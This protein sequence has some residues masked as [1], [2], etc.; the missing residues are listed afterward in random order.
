MKKITAVNNEMM[1]DSL[2][3]AAFLQQCLF[4]TTDEYLEKLAFK[5]F[6]IYK[7]KD[8]VSGDFYWTYKILDKIIIVIGDC[9]GHGTTGA[10]LTVLAKNSLYKAVCENRLTLPSQILDFVNKELAQ[11]FNTTGNEHGFGMDVSISVINKTKMELEY[12]GS[13]NQLWIVRENSLI[14][15][16]GDKYSIG[17]LYNLSGSFSSNKIKLKRHDLIYMFTDG[18]QDQFGGHFPNKPE[19]KKFLKKRLREVLL[20]ISGF[21]IDE[22]KVRLENII[23]TWKRGCVQTDDICFL[24]L[25]I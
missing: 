8:Y 10:L 13:N 21:S 18:Y 17:S 22:Q 6:L 20:S 11:S 9:T 7:P 2:K 24:G 12:S 23:S 3:H 1:I 15:F 4:G 5:S 16:S 25:K 19:G 14:E